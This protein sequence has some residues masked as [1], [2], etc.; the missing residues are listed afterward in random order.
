MNAVKDMRIYGHVILIR[1]LG[2]DVRWAAGCASGV[3]GDSAGDNNL[4]V[5][6]GK[7]H[8]TRSYSKKGGYR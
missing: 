2:G 8:G 3:Q 6:D 4:E 1:Q 7:S 5:V